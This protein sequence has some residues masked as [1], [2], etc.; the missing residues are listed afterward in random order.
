MHNVGAQAWRKAREIIR[1]CNV[2]VE[3]VDARDP[4][5]TRLEDAEKIAGR[6]KLLIV[7][8]KCDLVS[9]ERVR[10]LRRQGFVTINCKAKNLGPERERLLKA[11]LSRSEKNLRVAVIGYPNVGKSTIINLLKRRRSAKVTPVAGTTLHVQWVRV[12]PRV[13]LLDSPGVFPH[14]EDKFELFVRGALNVDA[15][16]APEQYA[17]KAAERVLGDARLRVFVEKEFGV[18]LGGV[19]RASEVVEAIARRRGWLLKGGE[20]NFFEASKALLRALARAPVERS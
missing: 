6:K 20:L 17:L 18:D 12:H 19:E 5:R 1:D 13:L 11:I 14:E 4:Q 3:V 10:E 8:N 9:R 7:A 15:L 2:V 16:P